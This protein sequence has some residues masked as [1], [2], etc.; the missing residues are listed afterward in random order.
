[1][2]YEVITSLPSV[3]DKKIAYEC[4]EELGITYLANKSYTQISGGEK[5]MVLIARALA[6]KSKIIILDEPT[7]NLDFG[8][9]VKVLNQIKTLG[10]KN[11]GIIMTTHSS[12]NFV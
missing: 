11:I 5:Q 10:K 12:Y 3:S 6:Q 4:L 9:Q 8:N 7:S 2:L 1:M